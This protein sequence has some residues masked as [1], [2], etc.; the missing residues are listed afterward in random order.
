MPGRGRPVGSL[1]KRKG[2]AQLSENRETK[3]NREW[4]DSKT[5]EER[6]VMR[7]KNALKQAIRRALVKLEQSD[8]WQNSDAERRESLKEA[9]ITLCNHKVLMTVN[10]SSAQQDALGLVEDDGDEDWEDID[11]EEEG[12]DEKDRVRQEIYDAME[13]DEPLHLHTELD[14]DEAILAWEDRR[15]KNYTQHAYLTFTRKLIDLLE[16]LSTK[17]RQYDLHP[18]KYLASFLD[19]LG[20]EDREDLKAA[21][22]TV[23]DVFSPAD[24]S[25]WRYLELVTKVPKLSPRK[26]AKRI[27][28]CWTMGRGISE[29]GVFNF[30]GKRRPIF[31]ADAPTIAGMIRCIRHLPPGAK[32]RE[33]TSVWETLP[34]SAIL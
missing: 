22:I 26:L 27:I 2:D 15:S 33:P 24:I 32:L 6:D 17:L 30:G 31:R 23:L 21:R 20:L 16:H 10:P 11:A 34:G 9:T 13:N 12:F 7:S 5:E 3:R 8:E 14:R 19:V 1:K 25:M 4:R 18:D 29:R 28:R